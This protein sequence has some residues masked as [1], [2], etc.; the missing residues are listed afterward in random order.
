MLTSNQD[1]CQ[2]DTLFHIQCIVNTLEVATAEILKVCQR[3]ARNIL[4]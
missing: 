3:W 4:R 2:F 1:I